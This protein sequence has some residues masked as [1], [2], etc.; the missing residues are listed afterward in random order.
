MD[1]KDIEPTIER[2]LKE[3]QDILEMAYSVYGFT[4]RD[5]WTGGLEMANPKGHKEELFC[6]FFEEY[7]CDNS[8]YTHVPLKFFYDEDF[9]KGEFDRIEKEKQEAIIKIEE[10]NRNQMLREAEQEKQLLEDLMKKYP[11]VVK[12]CNF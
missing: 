9:R 10:A 4:G 11:E 2:M 12:E 7:F 5:R 1:I 6:L 8:Y 3:N